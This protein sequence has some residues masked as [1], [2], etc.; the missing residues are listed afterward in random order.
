MTDQLS[1]RIGRHVYQGCASAAYLHADQSSA[2][3]AKEIVV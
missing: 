2:R 3:R 1:T